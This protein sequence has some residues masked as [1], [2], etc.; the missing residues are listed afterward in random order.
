MR[1]V[2]IGHDQA[3]A[4]D[5]GEASSGRGTSMD[6]DALANHIVVADFEARLLAFELQVLWFQPQR[7]KWEDSVVR[8]DSGG[9][10]E[11]DMREQ[12]AVLAHFDICANDAKRTN[13]ATFG[14]VSGGIDD[15]GGVDS[16]AH[17]GRFTNWQVTMASHAS[18]PSTRTLPCILTALLRHTITSTSMRSWSPGVTGLRNF[19]RSMP[20]K[21]IS[22]FSRSGISVSS[23]A[24]P[25]C[26]MASTI[27]T[28]GMIGYPGK[29]PAKCGSVAV[30][31]LM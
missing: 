24:P 21:T 3:F 28:P 13:R 17:A 18:L 23:N 31:F 8:A 26:A 12:F 6:G 15:G 30:T 1:D 19:A 7:R 22:L 16:R 5:A 29:W 2:S 20:V 4:A 25:A 10:L 9:P 11:H 27:S 14:N